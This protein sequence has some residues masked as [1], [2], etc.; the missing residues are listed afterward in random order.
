MPGDKTVPIRIDADIVAARQA[1]RSLAAELGFGSA[2][3][4]LIATAISELARNILTYARQGEIRVASVE[5]QGR[6]GMEI[7]ARDDG[8]GIPDVAAAM[9][10]GFSTGKG[11]GLGL[12]GARRMMDEFDLQSVVGKGTTITMKKFV[13]ASG[14]RRS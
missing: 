13:A 9:R 6:R 12:P 7:V 5:Q 3:V 1:G 8:P 10:D 14:V 2:E 11:L 4:T